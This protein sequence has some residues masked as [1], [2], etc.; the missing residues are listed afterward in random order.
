LE[1]MLSH[2]AKDL[3]M[4][5]DEALLTERGS[6]TAPAVMLE[7]I[8]DRSDRLDD[9]GI[10][11]RM[12]RFVVEGGA[13]QAHQPASLCDAD[14]VGPAMADMV[15]LRCRGPGRRAPFRNSSS[16]ACLP[17]NRSSAAIR[18]S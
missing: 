7:L 6:N 14:A 5:D 3:L 17:T 16:R 11:G 9:G 4:V 2:Q 12:R 15:S 1:T 10:I 18:A 13:R 8:A